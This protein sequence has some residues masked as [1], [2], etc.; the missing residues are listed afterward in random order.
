MRRKPHATVQLVLE[1]LEK[2]ALRLL[3]GIQSSTG[4]VLLLLIHGFGLTILACWYSDTSRTWKRKQRT[5]KC[6]HLV[7]KLKTAVSSSILLLLEI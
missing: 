7:L 1:R 3:G 4:P 5:L 2:T 6:S